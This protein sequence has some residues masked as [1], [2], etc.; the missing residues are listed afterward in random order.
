MNNTTFYAITVAFNIVLFTIIQVGRH[1]KITIGDA[2]SI[3][4][5]SLFSL[6]V[7]FITSICLIGQLIEK[8]WRKEKINGILEKE[9]WRKH[10]V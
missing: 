8:Y 6:L 5:M 3:I 4:F 10:K 7:L 2:I 9:L 1:Q